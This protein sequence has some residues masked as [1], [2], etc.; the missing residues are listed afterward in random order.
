M[1][2]REDFEIYQFLRNGQQWYGFKV[3]YIGVYSA[4]S[5]ELIM[6][7]RKEVKKIVKE[8]LAWVERENQKYYAR[9][10]EEERQRASSLHEAKQQE[11][12][13]MSMV[14]ID[15]KKTRTQ[16][17]YNLMAVG[18]T[19]EEIMKDTGVSA[20]VISRLRFEFEKKK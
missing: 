6:Q 8:K 20:R 16:A 2:T 17:I 9:L 19:N 10:A 3:D 5:K 14:D 11:I 1:A 4:P 7:K 12:R 18:F 13:A 15:D